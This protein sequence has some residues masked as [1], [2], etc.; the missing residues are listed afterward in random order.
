MEQ[1]P[2]R[3]WAEAGGDE[4]HARRP[5]PLERR[6]RFVLGAA[7]D[8]ARLR[9]QVRPHAGRSLPP[10]G[11]L[12]NAGGPTRQPSD[13]RYDQ[14][15]VT[16]PY[17]LEKVFGAARQ[18]ADAA[19]V[20]RLV[21]W[22]ER[23]LWRPQIV[24]HVL[25]IHADSRPRVKPASHRIHEH[26]GRLEMRGG[27]RMALSSAPVPRARLSLRCARAISTSGRLGCRRR[28]GCTRAGSP[29]CFR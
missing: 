15:E 16:T 11:D 4:A 17:E 5:E 26:V 23:F 12:S 18:S 20:V 1:H 13:C 6:Q 14:L 7:A 3:E 24:R 22:I 9:G 2:W 27:V 19:P 29:A 10:R 28:D 21:V 25:E 8:R